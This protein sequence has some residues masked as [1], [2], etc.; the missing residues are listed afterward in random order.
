[1]TNTIAMRRRAEELA[2]R[3]QLAA[4]NGWVDEATAKA[5]HRL[6]SR[7]EKADAT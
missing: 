5:L 6:L 1:M 2:R 7:I 3:V 4:R